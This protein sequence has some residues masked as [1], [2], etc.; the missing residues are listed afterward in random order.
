MP[1]CLYCQ[2]EYIV[3]ALYCDFCG[4]RLPRPTSAPSRTISPIEEPAEIEAEGAQEAEPEPAEG[5]A[6]APTT[7]P[8]LRLQLVSGFTIDLDS[9]ESIVIGRKDAHQEPDVDLTPYGGI[10]QGVGRRHAM[11]LLKDGRYY[12]EDL[13]S[14]NETLLNSSRLFPGQL[15]RLRDGDQLKFGAMAVKVLLKAGR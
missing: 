4:R 2:H 8:H 7:P 3:G 1:E 14:I 9:R 6:T 15:Y 11:I 10:E 13:K 12:I 5:E